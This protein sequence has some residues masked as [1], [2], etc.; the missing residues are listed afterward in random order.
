MTDKLHPSAV[1]TIFRSFF[2][3][4][5]LCPA[6]LF[7]A[8][9]VHAQIRMTD[10]GIPTLEDVLQ[11]EE[12]ASQ[13]LGMNLTADVNQVSLSGNR[14]G[15]AFHPHVAEANLQRFFVVRFTRPDMGEDW[16]L[17]S[18]NLHAAQILD[19]NVGVHVSGLLDPSKT[20]LLHQS[21]SDLWTKTVGT[22]FTITQINTTIMPEI[23]CDHARTSIDVEGAWHEVLVAAEKLPESPVLPP[24]LYTSGI[25]SVGP[26]AA[27][28]RQGAYKFTFRDD[29]GGYPE[30][31]TVDCA[32]VPVDLCTEHLATLQTALGIDDGD[33]DT[34]ARDA[35]IL[36]VLP[37]GYT[38]EHFRNIQLTSGNGRESLVVNLEELPVSPTR[39]QTGI[40]LCRRPLGSR[41]DWDCEYRVM[42]IN[43]VLSNGMT[44]RLR[45]ESLSD[46]QV[47][48]MVAT[49]AGDIINARIVSINAAE[50]GYTLTARG[51]GTPGLTARFDASL[52]LLEKK[53]QD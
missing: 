31:V 6:L 35:A 42:A 14:L 51:F 28:L 20:A 30:F 29:A 4:L 21:V 18:V 17:Q 36:A 26:D 8:S 2:R 24:F 43:V 47:E 12:I 11:A 49:V 10:D 19:E 50:G 9:G 15:V 52:S 34:S 32:T 1:R 27:R 22:D 53:F 48:T 40:V 38:R 39:T 41:G 44:V 33:E 46:A 3:I 37:V 45:D 16:H 5:A 23:Y 25:V 13:C 7:Q